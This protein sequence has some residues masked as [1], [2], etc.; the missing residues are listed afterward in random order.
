MNKILVT[1][2]LVAGLSLNSWTN[3]AQEAPTQ[4]I[5]IKKKTNKHLAE[6]MTSL[7]QKTDTIHFSD[8]QRKLELRN[9]IQKI[10]ENEIINNKDINKLQEKYEQEFILDQLTTLIAIIEKHPDQFWTFNEKGE[11][12][13]DESKIK[14]LVSDILFCTEKYWEKIFIG[15]R[16]TA[17]LVVIGLSIWKMKLDWKD[18]TE[19]QEKEKSF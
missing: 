6:T 2:G 13:L 11:Y 16:I 15:P 19:K 12:Q 9:E 1:L 3:S 14:I 18:E 8:A 17:V 4:K 5:L 7:A 10:L